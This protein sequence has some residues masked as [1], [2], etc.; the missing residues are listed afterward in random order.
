MLENFGGGQLPL[1][2]PCSA[3]PVLVNKPSNISINVP[4]SNKILHCN[5][6]KLPKNVL[7]RQKLRQLIKTDDQPN[8]IIN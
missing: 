1:L 8:V 3:S 7:L 5:R 6:V 4:C 2:P